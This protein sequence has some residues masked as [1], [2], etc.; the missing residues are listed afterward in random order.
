MA[1]AEV[2][3]LSSK[4][5]QFEKLLRTP[6]VKTSKLPPEMRQEVLDICTLSVEKHSADIERC[7]QV[8]R[9]LFKDTNIEV[10]WQQMAH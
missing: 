3:T 10:P 1:D 5:S 7:C 2:A 6:L 4:G 9:A 8:R